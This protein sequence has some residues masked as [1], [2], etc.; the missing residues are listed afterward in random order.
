MM[1]EKGK[2]SDKMGLTTQ[3]EFKNVTVQLIIMCLYRKSC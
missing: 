3:E 1:T 2:F